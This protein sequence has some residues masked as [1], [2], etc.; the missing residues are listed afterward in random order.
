MGGGGDTTNV[1]Q[2]S[3]LADGQ[4]ANIMGGQDAIRGDIQSVGSQT[5]GAISGLRGDMNTGFAGVN[6]NLNTIG[7][8]V[9]TIG[10]NVQTGFNNLNNGLNTVN[11]NVQTGI[12]TLGNDMDTGFNNLNNNLT[13]A[14]KQL[15]SDMQSGFTGVLNQGTQ[16]TNSILQGQTKGFADTNANMAKG[17]A[18]NTANVNA[19]FDAQGN[20]INSGFGA[21]NQNID[22]ARLALANSQNDIRGLVEKYG[23]NLDKYY[24]DL[25]A[26]Q[27]DQTTRLGGIQTGLATFQSDFAKS[28]QLANQQRARMTDQMTG[29][30]NAVR[31]NIG[32][33]GRSATTQADRLANQVANVQQQ[34][35]DVQKSVE[36]GQQRNDTDFARIAKEITVGFNDGSK[37]TQDNH[38]QFVDSIN[39]IK[40]L[41]NDTN[42][43]LDE[44]LRQQYRDL[45][46]SFD[47]TGKLIARSVDDQGV[48]TA[49]A[50]DN[51]G[52]LLLARFDQNG[53]RINEQSLN[54]N[55]MLRALS[56]SGLVAGSNSSMGS[57]T[58]TSTVGQMVSSPA[59]AQYSGL[60]TPY[61][62]TAGQ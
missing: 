44:G 9:Q 3:G 8:N 36:V 26:S 48:T 53:R 27:A 11:S 34:V 43:Q 18:D 56:A 14:S 59:A 19:R 21:T 39:T 28:D 4:Y 32:N 42:L 17:F 57:G 33:V 24:A 31:E 30:F 50:I 22:A 49:R 7:G 13:N 29:G 20:Q 2:V 60:M 23:G 16:N 54:I 46:D 10:T 5:T 47:S 25:A 45:S 37:Q 58:P 15:G 61:A 1:S 51:Q 12:N 35:G 41:V 38:R 6:N 62:I 55:E 52:R 40:G